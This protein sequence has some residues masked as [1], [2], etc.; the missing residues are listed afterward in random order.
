MFPDVTADTVTQLRNEHGINTVIDILISQHEKSKPQSLSAILM[1]H[2]S[3]HMDLSNEHVLKTNR[4]VL[5]NKAKVFYKRAIANPSILK[6]PL[7]IEFSGE[8]GADAGALLFEFSQEVMRQVSEEYFEG[9]EGRKIPRSHWGG[10]TELEM[11][12]AMVAHSMLQGGPGL[13][14]IHPAMYQSMVLGD[15][16]ELMSLQPGEFP[17]A[18]DIPRNAATMDLLEMINEVC[19]IY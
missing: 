8:E 17:T 2:A 3:L 19:Q 1:R 13:P 18:S 15:C 10:A 4:A 5:W 7:M 6:K 16:L 9:D 12:G 11:A 14:C